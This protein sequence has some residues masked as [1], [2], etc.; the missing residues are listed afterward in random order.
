MAEGLHLYIHFDDI[1][2]K[3]A[4]AGDNG[5]G[6]KKNQD[7]GGDASYG[8]KTAQSAMRAVKGMVSFSAVSGVADTIIS[9][10]I[11]MVELNTGATEYEQRLNTG[12]SIAKQAVGA[13]VSLGIG[14]ATGTWPLV[15]A[16]LVSQGISK[17]IQIHQ[18]YQRLA[19][20]QTLEGVSIQMQT[21]RAG[22]TGRR[23]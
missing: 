20:E 8:D 18:T 21:V 14:I 11:R 13:G 1:A 19:K 22:A 15:I 7:S 23:Q 12:Y 16:G 4:V 2:K 10:Q 5:G 6:A 3:S 17:L 9:H